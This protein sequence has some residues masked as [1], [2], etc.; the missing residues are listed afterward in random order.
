M[1]PVVKTY[2]IKNDKIKF[3]NRSFSLLLLSDFHGD[4]DVGHIYSILKT[5]EELKP[6]IIFSSG[7]MILSKTDSS[8]KEYEGCCSGRASG[9]WSARK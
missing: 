4:T 8:I 7:D 3:S 1:Y 2:V 6:D 9:I 5:A